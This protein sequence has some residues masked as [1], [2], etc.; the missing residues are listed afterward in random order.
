MTTNAVISKIKS[1]NKQKIESNKIVYGKRK[2]RCR[3]KDN[4]VRINPELDYKLVY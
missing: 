4:R 2:G 3:G 1:G